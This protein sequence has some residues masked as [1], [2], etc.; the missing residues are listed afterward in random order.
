MY[1]ESSPVKMTSQNFRIFGYEKEICDKLENAEPPKQ[2]NYENFHC[3]IEALEG[4]ETRVKREAKRQK[5][6]LGVYIIIKWLEN[7]FTKC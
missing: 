4:V 5:Q 6:S 7:I 3:W 2:F 1:I